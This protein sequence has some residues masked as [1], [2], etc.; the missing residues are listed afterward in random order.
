METASF[1]SR[2]EGRVVEGQFPLL[3]RLGGSGNCSSFLTVLQGSK[4]ATIQ[5]FL[6]GGAEADAYVAQWDF[7][8]ALS[9]PHLTRVFAAGRCVIDR[10]D[11]VYV[12]T[13]RSYATLSK[14]IRSRTLKADTAREFFSPVLNALSYL[15][16]NG[17]VHGYVNPT[18][19]LL[20]DLKPK[21]SATNLLIAGSATRS[22]PKHGNYDAPELSH[23][24]VTAAADTWSVGMTLW[25]AMTQA[26]P[27]W[28]STGNEEP[29][30]TESLPC[31]F[32]EIVQD[33]LRIDPLRRCTIQ[34]ILERLD[35][36]KSI[37]LADGPIPF[38]IDM[39][40]LAATPI[41]TREISIPDEQHPLSSPAEMIEVEK[42][43]D[44]AHFS[45]SIAHLEETHPTRFWVMPSAV[46][47]LAVIAFIS[48]LLVRR[49]KAETPSAVASQNAPAISRPVS[50]EQTGVP[51]PQVANPKEIEASQ[52]VPKAQPYNA[53]ETETQ[54]SP[55]INQPVPQPQSAADHA[56]AEEK[57][58]G[59]VAKQVLPT[60]LPGARS[61]M[62][63]PVEVI[64]RVSVNQDGTVSDAAYVSPGP[65]NYFARL[66][67]RAARS[68]EFTPP[69]RN[70]DP[71]R[72]VWT[73][74]FYFGREKT[75]VTATEEKR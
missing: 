71:E 64:M 16:Q 52:P 38:E 35:G 18:S 60:V 27:S 1:G 13:E 11:L 42:S 14:I 51:A 48:V 21:L 28:D 55:S 6:T 22:I 49:H 45:R 10:S 65:G 44:P 7:A 41:P 15:H 34:T 61:G 40:P 12:V 74:R 67:Q 39:P 72:S 19:I 46:V 4:E 43:S 36:S 25:E 8:M 66:A 17:V 20:A 54:A 47:F 70:G 30:V 24:E 56:L 69:T 29:L 57:T 5:L 37:P 73:L 58:K 62:R 32:G 26:L 3:E 63:E 33:C 53:P 75:D 59:L 31:P 9:H 2:W 23:G 50:Q 68:W